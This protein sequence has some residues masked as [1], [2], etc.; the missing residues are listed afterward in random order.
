[1]KVAPSLLVWHCKEP[2]KSLSWRSFY[3]STRMLLVRFLHHSA[4]SYQDLWTIAFYTLRGSQPNPPLSSKPME[5]NKPICQKIWNPKLSDISFWT[6]VIILENGVYNNDPLL[7]SF[8]MPYSMMGSESSLSTSTLFI[9]HKAVNDC[10]WL[11]R[12]HFQINKHIF[13]SILTSQV[14]F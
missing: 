14:H 13:R 4:I 12:A 8:K 11:T 2:P 9:K 10:M 3:L 7:T 6:L 5:K 1:M